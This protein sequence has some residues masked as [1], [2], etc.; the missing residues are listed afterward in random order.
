MTDI[1]S[2]LVACICLHFMLSKRENEHEKPKMKN[3]S[4]DFMELIT[5]VICIGR[6]M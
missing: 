1:S 6:N 5:N 3:D 4:I 2:S